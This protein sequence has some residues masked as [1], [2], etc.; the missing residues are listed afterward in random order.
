MPRP[1]LG[2]F[3]REAL[4]AAAA[5]AAAAFLAEASLR[6]WR[7][8]QLLSP[9]FTDRFG[10]PAFMPDSRIRNRTEDFDIT[11]HTNSLGFR[12]RGY[13]FPKRPGTFRIV[14]LGGCLTFGLGVEDLDAY[15]ARLEARLNGA[16]RRLRFEVINLSPMGGGLGSQ[17]FLYRAI[18]ARYQ[19]DIVLSHLFVPGPL[20]YQ[21]AARKGTV[22]PDAAR[23]K[24]QRLQ[25]L[26][27]L[28]PGYAW[29]CENSHLWALLRLSLQS[30]ADA[31][32]AARWEQASAGQDPA[33]VQRAA[34]DTY[35]AL[36]RQACGGGA[37]FLV[38]KQKGYLD[39]YP[40]LAD[41]LRRRKASG[42]CLQELELDMG[43]RHQISPK[44]WHWSRQGHAEVAERVFAALR[45]GPLR[46]ELRR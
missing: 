39:P 44:D 43:P 23:L 30:Q 20:T 7:P 14:S 2:P 4:L 15:S 12:G 8:Q 6:A 1:S 10:D 18:G 32:A 17:E 16:A 45:E 11:Y 40:L 24:V 9:A 42:S 41:Y 28:A 22:P 21:Y 37:R 36:V 27:R 46:G 26:V 3:A 29:L 35:D 13:R 33:D 34:I 31:L 5:L 25:R 38:L 19:P